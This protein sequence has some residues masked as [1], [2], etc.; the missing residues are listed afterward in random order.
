M[1]GYTFYLL[2]G[3]LYGSVLLCCW[4]GWC[5]SHDSFPVLWPVKVLRLVVGIFF[6]TFYIAALNIFLTGMQCK[7]DAT[8]K[9]IHILYKVGCLDM[10]HIIH[11]FMALMSSIVF[12]VVAHFMV[13]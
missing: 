10:P 12:A 5:F 13:S 11:F 4:V 7:G 1:Q 2:A 3:M 8:G 6:S 9:W